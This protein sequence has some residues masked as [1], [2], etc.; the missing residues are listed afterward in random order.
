M[1]TML[2]SVQ[3]GPKPRDRELFQIPFNDQFQSLKNFK[4][5]LIVDV[6]QIAE[7]DLNEI[8]LKRKH[9]GTCLRISLSIYLSIIIDIV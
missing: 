9:G 6:Y 7:A 2:N 8:T 4:K 3:H 1:C 5:I